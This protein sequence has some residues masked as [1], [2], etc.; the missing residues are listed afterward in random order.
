MS[1]SELLKE[2]PDL[3]FWQAI[4]K[5][6]KVYAATAVGGWIIDLFPY[7]N[8]VPTKS[9][10]SVFAHPRQNWCL[11]G[12]GGIPEKYFPAGLASVPVNLRLPMGPLE[13]K[14]EL[15]GRLLRHRAK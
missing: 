2:V 14:V 4:Y 7:L 13:Q 9:R 3:T 12:G 5:P 11:S 10:S 1:S 8:A 6:K 15:V